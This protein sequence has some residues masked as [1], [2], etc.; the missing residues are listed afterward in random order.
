MTLFNNV[1]NLET[2]QSFSYLG[3]GGVS[4]FERSEYLLSDA[5][6]KCYESRAMT[7]LYHGIFSLMEP[8]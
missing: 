2:L 6:A 1:H 4:S 8:S 5:C 3:F 7:R